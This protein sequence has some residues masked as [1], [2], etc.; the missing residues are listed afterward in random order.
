MAIIKNG[1]DF[2]IYKADNGTITVNVGNLVASTPYKVHFDIKMPNFEMKTVNAS[3]DANGSLTCT[4]DFPYTETTN[5]T[6]GNY[7]YAIKVCSGDMRDTIFP[8]PFRKGY[9]HVD[10][11]EIKDTVCT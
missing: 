10:E 4:F 6:V 7:P 1:N 3:T 8:T 9:F 11:A 2:Y 5:Y